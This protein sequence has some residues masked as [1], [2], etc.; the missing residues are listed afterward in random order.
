MSN[1]DK[2]NGRMSR[3]EME[4]AQDYQESLLPV[5]VRQAN[6]DARILKAKYDALIQ[7]GFNAQQAL[8]IVATRPL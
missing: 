8:H 5:I 1:S 6:I 2:P 4:I 3:A 7:E